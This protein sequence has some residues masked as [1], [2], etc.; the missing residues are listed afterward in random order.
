MSRSSCPITRTGGPGPAEGP[1]RDRA[2]PRGRAAGRTALRGGT[3]APLGD[4]DKP[5][6]RRRRFDSRAQ[7]P[8][9]GRDSRLQDQRLARYLGK[10][11]P[12]PEEIFP[13]SRMSVRPRNQMIRGY[14]PPERTTCA[15]DL[16]VGGRVQ[17]F[18]APGC[19]PC[20]QDWRMVI[21]MTPRDPWWPQRFGSSRQFGAGDVGLSPEGP[22]GSLR[23]ASPGRRLSVR[24][25]GPEA[26]QP[27]H[28]RR[29]VT[30]VT[31]WCGSPYR[32]KRHQPRV[33]RPTDC[34]ETSSD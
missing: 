18:P 12:Q 31:G 26:A 25:D 4:M 27:E 24:S 5:V 13:F 16:D 15:L 11:R 28:R 17:V 22:R 1:A 21:G 9:L 30:P 23:P 20:D 19:Q 34:R 2:A 32:T 14:A 8:G 29:P 10:G 3:E 7:D 6:P 33:G